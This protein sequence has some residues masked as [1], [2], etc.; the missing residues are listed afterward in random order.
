MPTYK[1]TRSIKTA[2]KGQ[3]I[4][5]SVDGKCAAF[6]YYK[7]GIITE[8]DK[9]Y[10]TPNHNLVAVGWDTTSGIEHYVLKNSYGITWGDG[11]YVRVATGDGD[12]VAGVNS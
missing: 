1:D 11:G 6:K 7:R 2:L 5:V 9:C 8:A 4:K 12:G 10:G 3:P